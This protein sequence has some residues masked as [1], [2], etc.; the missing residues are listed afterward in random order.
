TS[1]RRARA[2]PV[3]RGTGPG[4]LCGENLA[5]HG[6]PGRTSCGMTS[7]RIEPELNALKQLAED[8]AGRQKDRLTSAHLLAAIAARP[9]PAGL[10]LQERK[11]NLDEILRLGR[12]VPD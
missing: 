12:S 7:A 11:L 1:V 6:A 9:S 4:A 5:V 10:L 2:V 8:L 3:S